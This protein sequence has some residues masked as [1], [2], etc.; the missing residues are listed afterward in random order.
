MGSV[1]VARRT[2][3]T[4]FV[5]K[6]DKDKN[7]WYIDSAAS[8]NMTPYSDIVNNKAQS[9]VK[10]ITT[11]DDTKIQVDCVGSVNLN[12]LDNCIEA[13]EVLLVPKLS[14]NL[15]SVAKIFKNGKMMK[16]T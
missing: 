6:D 9:Q 13:K 15:L 12:F 14:V 7:D 11:A 3:F 16:M 10:H 5:A 4:A 1:K 2:A 8:S